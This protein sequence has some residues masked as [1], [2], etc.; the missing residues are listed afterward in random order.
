MPVEADFTRPLQLPRAVAGLPKLG[1]F[2]GS[3][4]GNLTPL[5]R[6]RPAARDARSRWAKARCC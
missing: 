2:P 6:D 4:I 1:F 3:T 5:T